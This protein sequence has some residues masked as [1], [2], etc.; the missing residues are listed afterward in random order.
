MDL[1]LGI[2]NDR[3]TGFHNVSHKYIGCKDTYIHI[4]DIY[5][6]HAHIYI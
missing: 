2:F 5:I 3:A 6:S 4:Y 1:S